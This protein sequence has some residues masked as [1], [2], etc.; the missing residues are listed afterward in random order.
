MYF[1]DMNMTTVLQ[2]RFS[3]LKKIHLISKKTLC[4]PHYLVLASDVVQI[5][6]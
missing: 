3:L 5:S 1:I 2:K 6:L 4:A